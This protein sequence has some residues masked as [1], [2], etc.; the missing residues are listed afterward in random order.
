MLSGKLRYFSSNTNINN[1]TNKTPNIFSTK[2]YPSIL[3]NSF[4]KVNNFGHKYMRKLRKRKNKNK[5]NKI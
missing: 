3:T 1:I 2:Y 5:N 4:L